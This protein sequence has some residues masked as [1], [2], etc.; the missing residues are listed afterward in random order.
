MLCDDPYHATDPTNQEGKNNSCYLCM[1]KIA[2]TQ[3]DDCYRCDVK[4]ADGTP[5]KDGKNDDCY[6]YDTDSDGTKDSCCPTFRLELEFDNDF[7]GRSRSS[8]G[9]GESGEIVAIQADGQTMGAVTYTTSDAT[10][11]AVSGDDWT[12]GDRACSAQLCAEA[13][14]CKQCKTLKIVEPSGVTIEK[15]AGTGVWHVHNTGSVGFKGRPYITAANVSFANIE[16]RE[17]AVA[18]VANGYFASY[19]GL[20]HAVGGWVNV[21]PVVV[22]KGSKV[23]G[24]DTISMGAF[25]TT[26]FSAGSLSWPIPWE[27]RVGTGTPKQFAVVTHLSV[28]EGDGA[29]PVNGNDGRCTQSK[30]GH[31]ETKSYGDA[32]SSY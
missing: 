16:V 15:E 12:A 20:M 10:C 27:F 7:Q 13:N 2:G 30:G 3:N 21:L 23:D 32:A 11:V 4:K 5:G 18:A 29:N 1:N 9:V 31:T 17:G 22:G 26:P 19:N 28:I 25:T 24:V 8:A 14:G 6:G